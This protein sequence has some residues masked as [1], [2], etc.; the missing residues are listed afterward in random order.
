MRKD[1]LKFSLLGNNRLVPAQ[2]IALGV[3][4]DCVNQSCNTCPAMPDG[5]LVIAAGYSIALRGRVSVTHLFIQAS[6]CRAQ[7]FRG[8]L[9]ETVKG[10]IHLQYEE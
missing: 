9:E 8:D 7:G 5:W 4:Q 3:E 2:N 10:P 1:F 6:I